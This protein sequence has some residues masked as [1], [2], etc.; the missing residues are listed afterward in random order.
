MGSRFYD[1]IYLTSLLQLQ[2]IIT[3]H[4]LNSLITSLSLYFV[5]FWDWSLVFYYLARLSSMT[6]SFFICLSLE[7]YVTT[8]VLS[9]SL[10][11]NKA[12][13]WGLQPDIY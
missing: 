6:P 2:F 9:A 4:T 3:A 1:W 12:P 10:S 5:L 11:C 13:I 7:S 8:D